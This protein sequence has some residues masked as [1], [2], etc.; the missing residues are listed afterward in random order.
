[1]RAKYLFSATRIKSSFD[2]TVAAGARRRRPS[3][4]RGSIRVFRRRRF[5]SLR[6]SDRS[7]ALRHR[8]GGDKLSLGAEAEE[9]EKLRDS[10]SRAKLDE[11]ERPTV[12]PIPRPRSFQTST[13]D[14]LRT[15][16]PRSRE[17]EIFSNSSSRLL[18]GHR[19]R[20]TA[21]G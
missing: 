12:V 9:E 21:A 11:G 15:D 7:L 20:V 18:R 14:K 5:A 2:L 10:R 8:S 4:A 6:A 3:H 16:F 13:N 17:A 19:V 1:V